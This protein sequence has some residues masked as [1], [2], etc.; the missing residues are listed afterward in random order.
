M[1]KL[2]VIQLTKG[3]SI[4]P[5]IHEYLMDKKWNDAVIVAE[6]HG[7]AVAP[8]LADLLQVAAGIVG[9]HQRRS[10]SGRCRPGPSCRRRS[11]CSASG[12]ARRRRPRRRPPPARSPSRCRGS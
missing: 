2:H 9:R 6:I 8:V 11:C 1:P 12:S 10:R 4:L 7:K 3:Q 5:A